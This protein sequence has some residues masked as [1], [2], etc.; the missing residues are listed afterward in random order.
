MIVIDSSKALHD[1][2]EPS[3]FRRAIYD[4]ASKV[5]YSDAVLILVGEYSADETRTEPEFAVADGIIQLENEANGPI[6]RRRLRVLKMRGAE[7]MSGQ[8][9]FRLGSEGF[10]AFPR[11]ETTL[12]R[13]V[14]AQDGRASFGLP[15][16]DAAIGG[17]IPR[18]DSTLA[19]GPSGV[20]K[21]LLALAFIDAGLRNGERCL[22]LSFQ[23][24]EVQ[25]REKAA[26]AGYDWT[27]YPDDQL[28][29]QHIAPVEV[30]L[31]QVG[32]LRANAARRRRRQACRG[33][34]PRGARVRGARHGSAAGL[35]VGARWVRARRRRD[36][37][38]HERDG[39]AR[40]RQ[41]PR[42][43]L[44]HLQQ[45]V[46]HALRRDRLEHCGED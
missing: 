21:T 46:L 38:L 5:A 6:D 23:E 4:L 35:R 44:V 22:H 27:A 18:G 3:E 12:P 19:I 36:N 45:R 37:D 11:L 41:R 32:T 30:D 24:T 1:V 25:V 31:D 14:A 8:H 28:T 2:V 20:G 34:Q 40:Q 43:A 16:L 9:S 33:R 29:I 13:H 42:R 39:R 26:A 7:V 17:G 10:E 15:A